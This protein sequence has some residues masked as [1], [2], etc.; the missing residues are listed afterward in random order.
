VRTLISEDPIGVK[1]RDVILY[2][3]ARNWLTH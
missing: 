3:N 1:G 2:A